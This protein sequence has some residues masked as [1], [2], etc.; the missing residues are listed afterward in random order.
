MHD[1]I[2]RLLTKRVSASA[3]SSRK[4]RVEEI[5]PSERLVLLFHKAAEGA[6]EEGAPENPKG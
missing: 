4:L 5:P 1:W 6:G 3:G 2:K